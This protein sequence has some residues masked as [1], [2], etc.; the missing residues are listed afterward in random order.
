[1]RFVRMSLESVALRHPWHWS[2]TSVGLSVSLRIGGL[3]GSVGLVV[4]LS[5]SSVSWPVDSP[6]GGPFP[7][8]VGVWP[9]FV[10][11]RASGVL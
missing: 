7:F 3:A 4:G 6:A 11:R 5:C 10:V 9:Q 8:R 1:M 2:N